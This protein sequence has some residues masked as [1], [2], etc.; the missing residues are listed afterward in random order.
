[1]TNKQRIFFTAEMCFGMGT[2]MSLLGH[3]FASGVNSISIRAFMIWWGPTVLTAFIFNL[4]VASKIT[5]IIIKKA[6]QKINDPALILKKI[7]R[8]RSWSM[9]TFMCLTMSTW[10]MIT[11]GAF[12]K[13]PFDVMLIILIRSYILAFI[14]RGVIVKPLA[15]NGMRTASRYFA[16]KIV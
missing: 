11:G 12:T 9:L 8:I 3:L 1:M 16:N 5:N 6:T 10:G 4:L 14:I 15:L 2:I 7:T 13:I